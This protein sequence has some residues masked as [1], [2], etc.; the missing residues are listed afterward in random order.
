MKICTKRLVDSLV[1]LLCIAAAPLVGHADS[2]KKPQI[3]TGGLSPQQLAEVRQAVPEVDI[4]TAPEQQLAEKA[5]S[6]DALV[7]YCSSE[8]IRAGKKL[9]W[10]QVLSAGLEHCGFD[11]L[12]NSP[13][14]VTNAK[15]IQGPEIADHAF[16]LLLSLTRS[17][18][19]VEADRSKQDWDRGRYRPIELRGKT[20]LVIGLGGIGTQIAERAFAFGMTVLAI[21]PKDIPF[22]NAVKQVGKPDQ[23]PEFL[24][25]ADVVFM[26]APHTLETETMLGLEEFALMKQGTYFVN[27]SRGKTVDTEALMQ[28]LK[29]GRLA[30]A[31]LDVTNP[32]PL[33]KGHPL[34]TMENVVITPHLAGQSDVF[35]Q[36]LLEL[37]KENLKRFAKG[38]PLHNVVDSSKGY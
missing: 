16:A 1:F 21:D 18:H 23:L 4:V 8:L 35:S 38:L 15:I 32:E 25:R 14:T 17:I 22:L 30:G 11:E 29:Q 24:P 2:G 33:P 3:L 27:V 34:W 26:S 28:A 20:A 12:K 9:R 6:A 5:A 19:R 13:I 31:G 37:V 7:G 36:R 10:V